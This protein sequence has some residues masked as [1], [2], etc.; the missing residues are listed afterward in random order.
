M[1]AKVLPLDPKIVAVISNDV[2]VADDDG[3]VLIPAALVA[4]VAKS[5]PEQGNLENW[6]L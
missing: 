6:R 5:A 4:E 1:T 3:A 2:I